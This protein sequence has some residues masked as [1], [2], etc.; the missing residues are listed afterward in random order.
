MRIYT[1]D[2]IDDLL[3]YIGSD[4]PLN[5]DEIKDV[6]GDQTVEEFLDRILVE[7]TTEY[8]SI[9]QHYSSLIHEV[10]QSYG[11]EGDLV[12]N[13]TKEILE[14]LYDSEEKLSQKYKISR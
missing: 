9:F 8:A 2:F 7:L 11:R 5:E 4:S 1:S 12:Q 3:L 6:I 14:K 13:A 10:I